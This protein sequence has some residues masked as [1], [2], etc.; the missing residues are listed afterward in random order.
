MALNLAEFFRAWRPVT[1]EHGW[2]VIEAHAV[3]AATIARLIG[4]TVATGLDAT[5]GYS[6]QYPV[7]PE[8][9]A[10]AAQAAGLFSR[11]HAEPAATA[12]GHTLLTIDHF[13]DGEAKTRLA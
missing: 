6:C 8:V 2:I 3:A 4:R 12:L 9:F 7:E 5:H 1:R 13:V 11:Q 10:W